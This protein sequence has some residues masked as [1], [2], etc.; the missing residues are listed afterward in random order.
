MHAGRNSKRKLTVCLLAD[1]DGTALNPVLVICRQIVGQRETVQQRASRNLAL[2][3][4]SIAL[5]T[6]KTDFGTTSLASFPFGSLSNS[7]EF[8][9]GARSPILPT[10][11]A[12]VSQMARRNC[13]SRRRIHGG[14]T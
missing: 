8:M 4:H 9:A 2:A 7:R 12:G 3:R 10:A 6:S 1:C 5:G 13:G 14:T 11:P